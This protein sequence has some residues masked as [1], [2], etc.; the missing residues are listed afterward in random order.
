ML[1]TFLTFLFIGV[2]IG[3]ILF[4]V[5]VDKRQSQ[6]TVEVA[7]LNAINAKYDDMTDDIITLDHPIGVPSIQQ[8][9]IPFNYSLDTNTITFS[10]TLPLAGGK[11]SLYYDLLNAYS[12]F[13][14]DQNV[15][16]TFDGVEVD[17]NV[18]KPSSWGGQDFAARFNVLPQCIQ[19]GVIDSNNIRFESQ[20]TLG[21]ENNFSLFTH[22]RRID[23]NISLPTSVD[24]YNSV[25]CSFDGNTTCPHQDYNMGLG[26]YL[27]ILFFDSNC[28]N[29]SL[30]APDK[31]ISTH[32]D[33]T[34]TDTLTYQCVGSNCSSPPLSISIGG[35]IRFSHT[36]IPVSIQMKVTFAQNINSFYFQ[37]ANYSVKKPGFTTYKSS[38][39]V[40]P[41]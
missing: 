4:R 24:D 34:G 14:E 18:P 26:P 35:G 39:V 32:F 3:L 27:T 15:Q 9:I 38:V 31:N 6:T 33:D 20:S 13:V 30:A 10:Q 37:D 19:Y 25:S 21:C 12:I 40:F 11:L 5:Q 16:H 41:Q 1:F 22:I 23:V 29:C 2:I 28:A 7:V 36:Q 17:L 8:R